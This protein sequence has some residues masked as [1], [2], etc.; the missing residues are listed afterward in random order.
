MAPRLAVIADDFTGLQ[1]IAAEFTRFGLTVA[2]VLDPMDLADAAT[3]AVDVIGVDTDSRGLTAGKAAV[4]AARAAA[5]VKERGIPFIYKQSDSGMQGH[6]ATE[7]RA[8]AAV[9]G[10]SGIVYAPSCPVLGRITR[11]GRQVEAYPDGRMRLDVEIAPI[12]AGN[13]KSLRIVDPDAADALPAEG[14]DVVIANAETDGQLSRLAKRCLAAPAPAPLMVGSVGFATAA[15]TA[16]ALGE[17]TNLS[18]FRP[19]LIIAG[20]LQAQTRRQ[21]KALDAVGR[22]RVL[23][24]PA[25][26]TETQA[27]AAVLAEARSALSSGE[28]CVLAAAD[29][30]AA[31]DSAYPYLEAAAHEARNECLRHVVQALMGDAAAA[32]GGVVVAGGTTSEIVARHALAIRSTR[33]AEWL[34]PGVTAAIATRADGTEL[35]LV[36]KAGTWGSEDIIL[37]AILWIQQHH[38]AA[39]RGRQRRT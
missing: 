23:T 11:G 3:A 4:A 15:A 29:S 17:K 37:R 20:S 32:F 39:A 24:L 8:I 33:I 28:H 21:L 1:A 35:P 22:C 30:G 10:A 5:L 18:N 13:A 12:W 36:T 26:L 6:I 38:R 9:L 27:V 25:S 19:V 7:A 16:L 14:G 31:S 34:S 2:T